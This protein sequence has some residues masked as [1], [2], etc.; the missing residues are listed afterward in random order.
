MRS[1][2][3]TSSDC[4]MSM[5]TNV[6][7]RS[8]TVDEALDVRVRDLLVE[9]EPEV[10]ELERDVRLQPFGREALE[11]ALVLVGDGLG[12]VASRNAS[13]SSVV[14]A[15]RPASFSLRRTA[16]H[17]SSVSP[18]TNRPAPSRMPCRCTKPLEPRAVGC[19]EDAAA[20]QPVRP[21]GAAHVDPSSSSSPASSAADLLCVEVAQR[22][23]HVRPERHALPAAR[24]A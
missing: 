19:A 20:Q 12:A 15:W 8:A 22:R 18:A 23:P 4:S 2:A 7:S 5:R 14:F 21:L 24:R 3:S 10:R 16:T 9:R 6:P 11:D 17:S 13:P 1:V